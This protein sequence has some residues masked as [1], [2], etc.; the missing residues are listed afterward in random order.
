[1]KQP[2]KLQRLFVH[3]RVVFRHR[4][5]LS[6]TIVLCFFLKDLIRVL[7]KKKDDELRKFKVELVKVSKGRFI[8]QLG[9][10]VLYI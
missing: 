7:L 4:M 1:M 8:V 10:A 2:W 9:D 5:C 3:F 6:S